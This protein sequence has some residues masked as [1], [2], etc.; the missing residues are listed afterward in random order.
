MQ[1]HLLAARAWRRVAHE[2]RVRDRM[3]GGVGRDR[4]RLCAPRKPISGKAVWLL[5]FH[6]RLHLWGAGA[7]PGTHTPPGPRAGAPWDF[8]TKQCGNELQFD[9]RI[10]VPSPHRPPDSQPE[11]QGTLGLGA[12]HG[13]RAIGPRGA[14]GLALWRCPVPSRSGDHWSQSLQENPPVP[15]RQERPL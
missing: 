10:W 7:P 5:G 1:T 6:L 15:A 11:A 13:T 12:P 2:I 3:R 4:R 8:V 14:L 9:E